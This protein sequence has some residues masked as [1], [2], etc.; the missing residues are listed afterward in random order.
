MHSN[1]DGVA[2][3][4][5]LCCPTVLQIL[6]WNAFQ[7]ALSLSPLLLSRFLPAEQLEFEKI[8]PQCTNLLFS[9]SENLTALS[10]I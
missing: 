3:A 5:F 4:F 1:L 6:L 2:L 10:W 9:E 7:R 8:S